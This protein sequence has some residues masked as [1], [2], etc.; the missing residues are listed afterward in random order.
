MHHS[1]FLHALQLVVAA[2]LLALAVTAL[3]GVHRGLLT[4]PFR[5][6]YSLVR[7]LVLVLTLG[8]V[9][10]S[11]N[12]KRTRR[13][14]QRHLRNAR[15]VFGDYRERR[16]EERA[17]ARGEDPFVDSSGWAS[18][19]SPTTAVSPPPDTP[20]PGFVAPAPAS[21][22][23]PPAFA[24]PTGVDEDEAPRLY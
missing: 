14:G 2:Y 18:K 6:L 7:I 23:L 20:G 12:A 1:I 15:S 19:T 4:Y 17:I 3:L 8:R 10:L 13:R 24:P 22:L 11:A 5:A 16:A 9:H 21:G